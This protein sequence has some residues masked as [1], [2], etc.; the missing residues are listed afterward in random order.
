VLATVTVYLVAVGE[1][2]DYIRSHRIMCV[3]SAAEEQG[4]RAWHSM[5]NA[6]CTY[7]IS[8]GPSGLLFVAG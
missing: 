7:N 3:P 1:A 5:A 6:T 4:L 2:D 8:V